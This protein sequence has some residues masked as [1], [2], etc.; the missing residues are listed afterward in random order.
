MENVSNDGAGLG[1]RAVRVGPGRGEVVGWGVGVGAGVDVGGGGGAGVTIGVGESVAI[2]V[3]VRATA[4]MVSR[5][6]SRAGG[7][8]GWS[9]AG[10]SEP[11]APS[12]PMKARTAAVAGKGDPIHLNIRTVSGPEDHESQPF[13]K[14]TNGTIT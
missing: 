10:A 8:D 7:G 12:T 13:N 2:G 5:R 1:G 14:P 3:T 11:T 6:W 9:E 4:A